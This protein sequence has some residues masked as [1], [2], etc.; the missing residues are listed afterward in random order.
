VDLPY[1]RRKYGA[2]WFRFR[3]HIDRLG[4][5][6]ALAE[7]FAESCD[8]L[9][10]HICTGA[11]FAWIKEFDANKKFLLKILRWANCGLIF[12]LGLGRVERM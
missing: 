4:K 5:Q 10:L 3:K 2:G 11:F 9:G 1:C 7:P 8:A 6:E 12:S